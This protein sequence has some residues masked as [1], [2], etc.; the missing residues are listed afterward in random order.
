MTVFDLRMIP[1]QTQSDFDFSQHFTLLC[2]VISVIDISRV[3]A[4]PCQATISIFPQRRGISDQDVR[5]RH[6]NNS[7]MFLTGKEIPEEP[8]PQLGGWSE[9]WFGGVKTKEDE[10][11]DSSICWW[12]PYSTEIKISFEKEKSSTATPVS[13][14]G[15]IEARSSIGA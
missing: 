2:S 10:V 11:S 9:E 3:S 1:S 14:W 8:Q 12:S 7:K 4:D 15:T 13:T 6:Q 5:S